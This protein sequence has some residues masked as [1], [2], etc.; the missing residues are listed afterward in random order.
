MATGRLRITYISWAP[1]CSRS[2]FTARELGGTS[3]MI[4]WGWLGSHPATVWLK[5]IGQAMSTWKVLLHESP[6]VVFVM[7]PPPLAILAVYAYCAV[8]GRRYVVDAHTGVFVTRR[9]R[10]FQRLHFWLCRRAITTIVTND[11]MA[12]VVRARGGGATVVPDVPIRFTERE[13]PGLSQSAFTVVYVTSF[14][15]DEPIAAMI[16]AARLL[17]DVPFFMTGDAESGAQALPD[18]LPSNLTLTGFLE[19]AAYG[20]LLSEAGVVVALTTDDHTMQRGAYEAIYHGTPVIVSN[21][22]VLVK[23]F[24]EGAVHV[25]NSP[26]ALVRAVL[27]VRDNV[28]EYRKGAG[29]LR[30][31]KTGRWLRAKEALVATLKG[32]GAA[33]L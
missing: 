9:W 27:R 1:H 6:D 2:D 17:P 20:R 11:H 29:R 5:Y 25:D 23:A 8:S 4:Y 7:T 31:R 21:T 13:S 18:H 14:D 19:S 33:A 32:Q 10:S 26:E 22:D 30:E 3:H 15:R 24:D 12:D 28:A 16:E